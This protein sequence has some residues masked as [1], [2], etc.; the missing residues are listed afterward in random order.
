MKKNVKITVSL[1]L[2]VCFLTAFPV[3]AIQDDE[4][5]LY[6][7]AQEIE[8]FTAFPSEEEFVL[9]EESIESVT[10]FLYEIADPRKIVTSPNLSNAVEYKFNRAV[11][12]LAFEVAFNT[13]NK[14]IDPIFF[15]EK[16][17]SLTQWYNSLENKEELYRTVYDI[18]TAQSISLHAKYI[19]NQSDVT[20]IFQHGWRSQA[21]DALHFAAL[22]SGMGYNVMLPDSRSRGESGGKYMTFGAYEGGDITDWIQFEV[23]T[24][25]YQKIILHGESMG[26]ATVMYSQQIPHPNVVAIIDDCGFS[27]TSLQF[28]D[29]LQLVIDQILPFVPW[30]G[31]I[32]WEGKKDQLIDILDREFIQPILKTDILSVS[33][34]LSVSQNTLPKL[35]IHGTEDWFIPIYNMEM[36][37][38]N[39]SG[40]KKA[41]R[42]EGA[43]HVEAYS[44][45][46][47]AYREIITEFLDLALGNSTVPQ[48]IDIALRDIYTNELINDENAAFVIFDTF[49][50]TYVEVDGKNEFKFGIEGYITLSNVF[51]V[52]INRYAIYQTLPAHGYNYDSTPVTFSIDA[53]E[54]TLIDISL[55][56]TPFITGDAEPAP[57]F[58]E[59]APTDSSE[60]EKPFEASPAAPDTSFFEWL[61]EFFVF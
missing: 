13:D 25:P 52:G 24:R 56:N 33:P 37:Y 53:N 21:Q 42:V 57:V 1:I 23:A 14:I 60:E 40:Y 22:F 6:T 18:P 28:R 36:L 11:A 3:Q 45:N 9:N 27:S 10:D 54:G 2:C 16:P 17:H 29:V 59:E 55:Y 61:R 19:D 51:K 47:E 46:P 44:T 12:A 41:V 48:R 4:Q 30:Y 15:Q 5:N 35:F 43:G 50:N 32:D 49:T 26:A 31:G 20:V 39:A 8:D 58:P 7:P 34:L 38:G